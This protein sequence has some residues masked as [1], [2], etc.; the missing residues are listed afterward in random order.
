MSASNWFRL[1][2]ADDMEDEGDSDQINQEMKIKK[3]KIPPNLVFKIDKS[4]KIPTKLNQEIKQHLPEGTIKE[5]KFTSNGNLL[6][7]PRDINYAGVIM[8]N[9]KYLVQENF[10]RYKL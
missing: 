6:V 4:F 10:L 9:D 5:I 1:I 7:Y 8:Q 2:G 3:S